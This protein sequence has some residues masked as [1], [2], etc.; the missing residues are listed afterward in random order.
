MAL[1][2]AQLRQMQLDGAA[3]VAAAAA[4]AEL[5]AERESR[6]CVVCLDAPKARLL[7]PC[8]HAC[9]CGACADALAARPGGGLCPVCRERIA[10]SSQRFY[11]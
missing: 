9:V 5:E 1:L 7:A 6:L 3:A 4:A 2:R 10:S 8:G 11:A